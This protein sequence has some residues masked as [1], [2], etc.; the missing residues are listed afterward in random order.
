MK[1]FPE[2]VLLK[3]RKVLIV[4][5]GHAAWQKVRALKPFEPRL[6][7][8]SPS[9]MEEL[10]AE[11]GLTL[12][13][14]SFSEDLLDDAAIVIAATDDPEL[15]HSISRLAAKEKIPC[16]CVDDQEWCSFIF[17]ALVEDENLVVGISTGGSSPSAAAWLKQEIRNAIPQ[18]F[19]QILNWLAS[20]REEVKARFGSQQERGRVFKA[21]FEECLQQNAPLTKSQFE[22]LL[23]KF[24]KPQPEVQRNPKQPGEVVL[25]GAGCGSSDLLTTEV[26]ELLLKTP[27]VVYDD[28][29]D[30]SILSLAFAARRIYV[31][32]RGGKPSMKQAEINELLLSLAEEYPMVLRLKGGDP[33]VFGRGME[34]MLFLKE[35]GIFCRE[36]SGIPSFLQVPARF[37]IPLTHRGMADR[38]LVMTGT[39]ARENVQPDKWK[40]LG[41]FDGSLLILMGLHNLES[42]TEDLIAGGM[43][44]LKPSAVLSS[45]S[46]SSSRGCF[47]PLKDL[48]A[49]ARKEKMV[50]PAVIMISE[51][52]SLA[53]EWK[54]WKQNSVPVYF[55][56][57][58]SFRNK[59]SRFLPAV[60]ESKS[61]LVLR[62]EDDLPN[63]QQAIDAVR[64]HPGIVCFTSPHGAELFLKTF[65]EEGLDLRSL[66][67]QKIC[68]IGS[69]TAGVF[70]KAGIQPDLMPEI[71]STTKLARAILEQLPDDLSVLSLRS[72]QGDW[73]MENLLA[74]HHDLRRINLYDTVFEPVLSLEEL[75]QH[76]GILVFGSRGCIQA[77]KETFGRL[78]AEG[79]FVVLSE[80]CA[81]V[82]RNL[83]ETEDL[84]NRIFISEMPSAQDTAKAIEL[85]EE[86]I[87]SLN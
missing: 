68:V 30:D 45:E 73:R 38:F 34:E 36:C 67:S 87:Y 59:V 52:V 19:G 21:L 53:P 24:E 22:T 71:Y 27:V 35:H 13:Q 9:F 41:S 70:Q 18:G 10:K 77:W 6:V 2:F 32:K 15:N 5:G 44:P 76:P 69:G 8:V 4:G 86:T 57:S 66:F 12:L 14:R 50:S 47:A 48:A 33:F 40:N 29:V 63:L 82:L 84:E 16:N 78:P 58:E 85:A 62:Q 23:A 54:E 39:N 43:D 37:G 17:P 28:L 83:F 65:L 7:L 74:E 80:E 61:A 26:R 81:E 72:A 49:K 20:T 75:D 64:R 1:Y 25:A 3:E 11:E 31:G 56:S 51:T 55:A 79:Q 46:I 42:I 60:T